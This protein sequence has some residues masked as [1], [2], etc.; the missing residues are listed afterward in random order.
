MKVSEIETFIIGA[1]W[2]NLVLVKVHTDEGLTGIGEATLPGYSRPVVHSVEALAARHVSGENPFNIERLWQKMYR[3]DMKAGGTVLN[4]AI[5]GIEMAC[6]DIMG[7]ALEVP[8]HT[9][10]GGKCNRKLRAYA[11]GWYGGGMGPEEF[12]EEATAVKEKGYKAIKFSPFGSV[13]SD[14]TE[15]EKEQALAK[16]EVVHQA[17]GE[18]LDLMIE[19]FGRFDPPQAIDIGHRIETYQPVF[20]EEPV[21]PENIR[22]MKEVKDHVEIPVAAG[23]RVYTKYGFEPWLE[24]RALDYVQPDIVQSGGILELKKIASMAEAKFI[25]ICPHNPYG[26]VA[27]TAIAHLDA[28]CTN[29][30]VQEMLADFDVPWL[31]DLVD[32]PL[33]VT[34]GYIDV[35]T[36]PGLGIELDEE[37]IAKHPP[38]PVD[39]EYV[40][41][42]KDDWESRSLSG[43]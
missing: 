16:V 36:S 6:W 38:L 39:E 37:E 15:E 27:S 5:A 8:V 14:I 3:D 31:N 40:S 10:I 11:N 29:F 19:A 42:W 25:G 43:R 2:R 41:K 26:P 12:A 24:A 28:T 7:K 18:D 35:P 13:G 32:D 23:E 30:Y 9:L 22:A 33:Q 34:D 17:V 4:S 1:N 21:G 20:Y